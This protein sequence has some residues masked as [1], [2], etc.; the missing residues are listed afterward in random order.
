MW[1]TFNEC[2]FFGVSCIA[3]LAVLP[4]ILAEP[5]YDPSKSQSNKALKCKRV[6]LDF[7]NT[8]EAK[9]LNSKH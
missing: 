6:D 9:T 7:Y 4:L 1:L 2:C 3:V 8:R 5:L